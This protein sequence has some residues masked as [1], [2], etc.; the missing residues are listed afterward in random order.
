M[1]IGHNSRAAFTGNLSKQMQEIADTLG[2]GMV[3]AL[4]EHFAGV[5]LRIPH[6]LSPGHKLLV[7]GEDQ[8]RLLCRFYPEDTI[9]VP[10]SLDRK[11]LKRQVD[12]LAARGLKRWEI[13][14]ELG[15]TQR[16]VRRLANSAPPDDDQLDLFGGA[17]C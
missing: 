14:L 15:I 7:L 9:Y 8:A 13:A 1:Q 3:F 4:V 11:R 17:D 16:H 5:E 6:E 10:L 2:V 12:A